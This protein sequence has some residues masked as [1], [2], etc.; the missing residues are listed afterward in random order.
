MIKISFENV[1]FRINIEVNVRTID[2]IACVAASP[3]IPSIILNA[4][5]KP[6]T[7]NNVI[8]TRIKVVFNR[9]HLV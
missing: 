7:A 3:S 9:Q 6:T 5:I 4:L 8:K 1:A 2:K